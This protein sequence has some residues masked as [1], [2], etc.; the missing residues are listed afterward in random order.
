MTISRFTRTMT[1]TARSSLIVL[2]LCLACSAGHAATY[3]VDCDAADDTGD[4]SQG[5][6]KKYIQSGLALMLGG[7]TLTRPASPWCTISTHTETSNV[8]TF[9]HRIPAGYTIR[10]DKILIDNAEFTTVCE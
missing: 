6:P 9:M 1:L 5:S 8:W 7:D 10:S 4:G 2:F 3:Y